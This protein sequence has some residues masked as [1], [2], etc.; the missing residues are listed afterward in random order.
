VGGTF[1][2][3]LPAPVRQELL[4]LGS[5]RLYRGGEHLITFGARDRYVVILRTGRAKVI[6]TTPGGRTTLLG[7]RMP[8]DVVGELSIVDGRPRSASVVA[9]GELSGRV[10]PGP[11]FSAFLDHHPRVARELMRMIGERLRAAD[12]R[13]VEFAYEV[14]TRVLCLLVEWLEA[15]PEDPRTDVEVWLTQ[16]EI[17]ELI[18]AA[19]VSVQKAMRM[20]SRAGLVATTY[21]R[22]VV[23]SPGR[24]AT[25]A[26]RLTET[27]RAT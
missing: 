3:R 26:Q 13:R 12:R 1:L 19:E 8:G 18:G 17:A 15:R 7:I 4:A 25:E 5:D 16:R 9:A 11:A 23:P 14:P 10:V 24:L 6:A 27:H 21:G 22:V 2:G 20:F